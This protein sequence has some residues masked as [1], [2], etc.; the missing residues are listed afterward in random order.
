MLQLQFSVK[1]YTGKTKHKASMHLERIE[2]DYENRVLP[3]V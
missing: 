3:N 1:R 2:Q